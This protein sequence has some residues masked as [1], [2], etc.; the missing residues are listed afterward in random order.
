MDDLSKSEEYFR[1]AKDRKGDMKLLIRGLLH[2]VKYLSP[3]SGREAKRSEEL[4]N[5]AWKYFGEKS[6]KNTAEAMWLVSKGLKQSRLKE[7]A[8]ERRAKKEE[9]A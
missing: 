6:I 9:D 8:A 1:R 3:V 5:K 7:K 2:L 4:L